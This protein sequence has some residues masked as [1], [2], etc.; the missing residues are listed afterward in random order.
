MT[1]KLATLLIVVAGL[2]LLAYVRLT[3]SDPARWHVAVATS[4]PLPE[5]PCADQI[6]A[7]P[8]GARATCGLTLD[9]QATLQKLEEIAL[10]SPRTQH[11]AGSAAEG[12]P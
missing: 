9:P 12:R 1:L 6:A 3:P 7:M 10:T 5:G 11:L 8:K 2:A 4:G